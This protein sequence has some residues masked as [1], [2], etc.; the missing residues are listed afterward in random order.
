MFVYLG[1]KGG[2]LS[3]FRKDVEVYS[4]TNRDVPSKIADFPYRIE[5]PVALWYKGSVLVCAGTRYSS[6]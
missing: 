4:P 6:T 3:G 5:R 2:F 1:G